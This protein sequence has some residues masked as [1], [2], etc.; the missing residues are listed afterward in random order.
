MGFRVLAWAGDRVVD[1]FFL[2]KKKRLHAKIGQLYMLTVLLHAMRRNACVVYVHGF[3]GVA[4]P[5][6]TLG[7]H[8]FP[9]ASIGIAVDLWW[10]V[11][12]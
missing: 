8:P 11:S 4:C 1:F 6:Q 2:K 3:V 10:C 12:C 7:P 9:Q 5:V